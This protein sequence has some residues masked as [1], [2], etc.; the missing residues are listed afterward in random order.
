MNQASPPGLYI[1]V[2][3]CRR[4][5]NYCAFFSV[6]SSTLIPR[7]I[8][9]IR[10]EASTFQGRYGLFDTLYL[11]G[12]TPTLLDP[13]GLNRL[14]NH[15]HFSFDIA[16]DGELTI[17]ANPSDLSYEK[18][19]VLRDLGFN[20]VSLGVQS[21][22][23]KILSF[24]GRRQTAA[25]NETALA[26]LRKVGFEN[27]SMDLIYGIE[28]Q[29]L[30]DWKETLKRAEAFSPEHLSCYQLTIEK[31]TPFWR[32]K[33]QG[34]LHTLREEKE[35][36]FFF[37]TAEYLENKGYC[38]YEVS[39]FA[40][41]PTLASRHNQ[42][43][44]HHVAYLGLGP[45]AHSFLDDRRWWNI[46]S[47]RR[48]VESLENGRSPVVDHE[49]IDEEKRR[50]EAVALGLRT[51]EGVLISSLPD[52][53]KTRKA[54]GF[55]EEAGYLRAEKGRLRPTRDGFLVADHLPTF[56]F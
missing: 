51:Q 1:H 26:T 12:G 30:G 54:V 25:E 15:I 36:T 46:S 43:Y 7:W 47:L 6:P 29:S 42:K 18:A 23:D 5:C 39:N 8:E 24:L 44:W 52:T 53:E 56:F 27:I 19:I 32:L 37:E 28:G 2:P 9:A 13:D 16:G 38:H 10:K 4:K 20:R 40:R 34:K 3:F 48:Y 41:R 45:S 22:N 31:K 21:F 11:G 55:L 35:A 49:S 50:L 33:E 14:M 17:E